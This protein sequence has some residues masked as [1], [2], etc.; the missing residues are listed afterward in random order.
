MLVSLLCSLRP[1]QLKLIIIDPKRLEFAAYDGI[2]HLLFP[3]VTETKKAIPILKWVVQ[4]M[5][6]RYEIM[7]KY[8]VRNLGD[9][10]IAAQRNKEMEAMP[11]IVVII[12]EL[13]DLMM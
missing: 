4:T 2:A 13:A 6:Q 7:A 11:Y 1:D 3:I 12:D 5:E 9:Y 10:K 8:G